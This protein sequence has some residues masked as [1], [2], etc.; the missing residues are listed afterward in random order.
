MDE[1]R[2]WLGKDLSSWTASMLS[3][4]T[5]AYLVFALE[6]AGVFEALRRADGEGRTV[7]ELAA[8]CGLNRRLL[9][10]ALT[11]L[12]LADEVL[13]KNDG[14]F[15]LGE[16]AEWLAEDMT[17]GI[18]LLYVGGYSCLLSNL[19]PALRE[20]KR[21][22]EDFVRPGDMIA[23][24]SYVATR[25]NY[26]WIVSELASLGV[27]VVA[28]L[29]CG[30]AHILIDVCRRRPGLRGVGI[31][32]SP[33]ALVEARHS[34]EEAG[35]A[36]R[37]RLIQGDVTRPGDYA[38]DL[39]DV[40]AFNANFVLHEFLRDGEDSV[41]ELLRRMK[42]LFPGRYLVVSE[43]DAPSDE[44][45]EAYPIPDR[46]FMLFY[47]HIIHPMSWQGLPISTARWRD[48]YDRAGVE[49]IK[50]KQDHPRRLHVHLGRF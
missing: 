32:I 6:E 28:D 10:G 8:E 25:A 13:A 47:Q 46:I 36:D 3:G 34:V 40:Q 2:I 30:A 18:S 11:F 27:E 7:D 24:G 14:R 38:A 12:A 48:I 50:I 44:Q 16:Q 49:I 1:A 45:Y 41:V 42:Y 9:D 43:F 17:R 35:L 23:R 4:V 26:S 29:G 39:D 22:G 37:I 20:E 19:L 33:E 15:T 21:Y 5:R 31:D